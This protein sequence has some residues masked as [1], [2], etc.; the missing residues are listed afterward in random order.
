MIII[1]IHKLIATHNSQQELAGFIMKWTN[2][3]VVSLVDLLNGLK[4]GSLITLILLS[5]F[6]SLVAMFVQQRYDQS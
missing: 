6:V 1:N 3:Q 4:D 2:S 5:H